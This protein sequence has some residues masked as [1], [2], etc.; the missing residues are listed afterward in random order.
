M[1]LSWLGLACLALVSGPAWSQQQPAGTTPPG[2][3][4]AP[5][6]PNQRPEAP[7]QSAGSGQPANICKELVAFLEEQAKKAQ[8]AQTPPA[9]Q[10]GQAPAPNAPPASSEAQPSNTPPSAG[11]AAAKGG[12]RVQQSSGQSAPIPQAG[13]PQGPTI[14]IEQ[15]RAWTT[16]NDFKGCQ[17]GTRRLR[18]AGIALP[19]GLLA[20]AALKPELVEKMKP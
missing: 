15:A 17:D 4:V 19:P 5:S 16:A 3:T 8:A 2:L 9:P 1:R 20:L 7:Q 11:Q 12:E 13:A 6:A 18:K 14:A 10:A